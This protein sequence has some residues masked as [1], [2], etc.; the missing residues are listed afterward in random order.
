MLVVLLDVE[1][2]PPAAPRPRP[3]DRGLDER[4]AEA[5]AAGVVAD[6]DV[7]E[8][9]V[10]DARPRAQAEAELSQAGAAGEQVHGVR[11]VQELLDGAAHRLVGRRGGAP[12]VAEGA[13]QARDRV[14]VGGFGEAD[15]LC[16]R[17]LVSV[18]AD[19][20]RVL[21]RELLRRRP[22]ALEAPAVL[23]HE[24]RESGRRCRPPAARD[25]RGS[26]CRR[27]SRR[28]RSSTRPSGCARCCA[29]AG[30]RAARRR[31]RR[32]GRPTRTRRARAAGR[33]RA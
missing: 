29:C 33:R 22:Q 28:R 19:R 17:T 26:R 30:C 4:A 8:P 11:V 1:L 13:Q 2:D 27:R 12:P 21:R 24:R 31:T 10:L 20:H 32:R 5:G 15:H 3:L 6:E 9:A 14:Q 23:L 16:P 7:L 18:I 25:R